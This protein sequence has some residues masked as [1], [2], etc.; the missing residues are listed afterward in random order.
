MVAY[1]GVKQQS[2]KLDQALVVKAKAAP[3]ARD[4]AVADWKAW[5]AAQRGGTTTP[6]KPG[7]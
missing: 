5:W 4:K 2:P 7:G 6:G 3:A 1:H